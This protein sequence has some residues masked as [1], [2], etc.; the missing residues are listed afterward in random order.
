MR[1]QTSPNSE[2]LKP[3]RTISTFT[4]ICI[5]IADM[6]GIG[7]FTSLGF[8]VA[9]IRT[10]FPI[11][12]LWTLG[13]AVALCGALCYGELAAAMPRSG[14]EYHFLSR[15]YHPAAGF[16][17]GWISATAGF[18]APIALAAA[19]FGSYFHGVFPGTSALMVSLAVAWIT[20]LVHLTHLK[21]GSAYHN[22]STLLKIV[23][24]LF[25]I[26]VGIFFCRHPQPIPFLPV[27]GDLHRIISAPFW[28]SL[29]FVLYS[30]SGWN[31]STYIINEIR[32]P[33]R[34]VPRSLFI[35]TLVVL[36]L[37][38]SLN[39]IFLHTTPVD[40]MAGQIEI[41]QIAG[42]FNFGESGANIMTLLICLCLLSS[43]SSMTWI[44]PRV[45]MTIGED[46]RALRFFAVKN[47]GDIPVVA[48]LFQI[49]IVT[50]LLLTS[51]FEQVL[52][53]IGFSLTL[54]TFFTVLGVIVLRRT[55]PD[56][57]RPYKTWGYPFTPLFF[58]AVTAFT[59]AHLLISRPWASLASLAT[60]LFGLILYLI[61]KH[62]SQEKRV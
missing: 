55:R 5:V 37:Y 28:V 22:F 31:A 17:A 59:M 61:S 49:A 34:A 38:V 13:G 8:Q 12:L 53:Y 24:I 52:V 41:G 23:T 19:A 29:I 30:Y 60:A 15:I 1:P 20:A 35:G 18:A 46:F 36:V 7:V 50:L 54:C 4:A 48:S 32:Q 25:I 2:R 56:L 9:D 44:G 16:M 27:N 40:Q 51:S 33:K 6:I 47:R 43:L 3:L 42:R 58:L 10:G 45:A 26:G 62:F 57:P 21:L 39:A 14:G 11:L